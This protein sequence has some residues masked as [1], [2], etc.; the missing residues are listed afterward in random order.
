MTAFLLA[1]VALCSCGR[2]ELPEQT[3]SAGDVV[4]R[5]GL[6]SVQTKTWLDSEGSKDNPTKKVY[7]SDGDRINVNGQISLPVSVPEGAKVG[8]ADFHLRSVDGPYSVIYPHDI[9]VDETYDEEGR[10]TISLASSQTYHPTTFSSGAAVMYGYTE[11]EDVALRNLCAAL[12]VNVTGAAAVSSATLV[13]ESSDAPICGTFTLCPK[14]GELTPVDGAVTLNLDFDEVTISPEGTDFYFTVPAGDYSTGLSFYFT[15]A[16][17]GR[18]MQCVWKPE[19][20]LEAGRLYSFND[21]PYAPEAKDIESAQEWEEFV[22]ALNGEGDL[23]KYLYKDGAVRLGADIETDIVVPGEFAYILDGAGHTIT[24][25]DATQALFDTVSGEIKNLNLA[26]NLTLDDEGAPMV[27]TLVSGGKLSGCTN[28]MTVY[29]EAADHAYVSGLVKLMTGGVIEN[30]I[31][32]G[33][34]TAKVD[35]SAADKNV[36]VGGIA[37]QVNAADCDVVIRNCQNTAELIVAPVSAA[38]DSKGMKVSVLGGIAGWLRAGN[39]FTIDNCD[40]SGR[41]HYSAD[42]IT[43]TKGTK[44]YAI[45]VGGVIGLAAPTSHSD[46]VLNNPLN[47][48]GFDLTVLNCDNTGVVSNYGTTYAGSSDTNVKAYTGGLFGAILG[49]AEKYASIKSCTSKGHILTYDLAGDGTSARPGFC[50]VAGGLAG[51]GGWLNVDASTIN[52]VIGSGKRAMV[53]IAGLLGFAL[54]PFTLTD[55]DLYYT[56]YFRCHSGYAGNRAVVAVVPVL[57]N[58]NAMKMVPDVK[59]TIISNCRIGALLNTSDTYPGTSNTSELTT[60]KQIF[61][62]PE[63]AQANLVCGQ[64]YT[65]VAEDVTIT[66]FTYWDGK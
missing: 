39:S 51:F 14:T 8:E 17:D 49:Q 24:R 62:T 65:T 41:I 15:N 16:G 1:A 22:L 19:T 46:G 5:A 29:F 18:K 34:V 59:G 48:D 31:N 9:V 36:A 20:A 30:C 13:S 12:R 37:A 57:Y 38:D 3:E 63:D 4:L 7:W 33:S 40:N 58:K 52:C 50:C 55:S 53:S 47:V 61:T 27:N 6:V 64:G 54:R 28:G 21:V 42:F 60:N 43:S 45:C 11:S 26:G 44:A 23:G 66:G 25:T 2:E 32:N 10:I 56:G 35:V